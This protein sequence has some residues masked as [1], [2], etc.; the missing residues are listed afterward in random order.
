MKFLDNEK[1]RIALAYIIAFIFVYLL[2]FLTAGGTY[3]LICLISKSMSFD[4]LTC[5][6]FVTIF[7]FIG[8]IVKVYEECNK[9]WQKE[10]WDL[11]PFFYSNYYKSVT[12]RAEFKNY[13]SV[14]FLAVRLCPFCNQSVIIFSVLTKS[15]QHFYNYFMCWILLW[16]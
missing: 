6:L 5:N 9:D 1:V 13:K 14:T 12:N 11:F 3:A 10:K 15:F 4:F 7:T 8:L 2:N 16:F